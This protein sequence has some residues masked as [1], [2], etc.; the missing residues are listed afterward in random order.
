[1]KQAAFSLLLLVFS[2]VNSR[3][4]PATIETYSN[5]DSAY[6]DDYPVIEYMDNLLKE[7]K[8]PPAYDDHLTA[9]LFPP[10][11]TTLKTTLTQQQHLNPLTP[12][13]PP[14]NSFLLSLISFPRPEPDQNPTREAHLHQRPH[15]LEQRLLH[16]LHRRHQRR[17]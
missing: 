3:Y 5:D 6:L 13:N 2:F 7:N 16:L 11:S 12:S 9:N 14:F 10:Q 1:M 4:Q 8:Q 15:H 17:A